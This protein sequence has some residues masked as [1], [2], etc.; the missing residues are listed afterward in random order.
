MKHTFFILFIPLL[1]IGCDVDEEVYDKYSAEEFYT[2]DIGADA[3][4]AGVYAQ[5]PGNWDGVG[6]AGADRGWYDI[7]S[8][9]SDEQVIPHRNTGD[10]ELA[11]ANLYLR[12]WLPTDPFFANAWNWLYNSIFKANLAIEQL[13]NA[14]TEQSKLAEAHALRAFFYY[15]L[16]DGFGNV[17]Y[18]IEN[19]VSVDAIPQVSR[20]ELF[21]LVVKELTE[22]IDDLSEEKGGL[23]YGR[24]NKWAGYSLLAKLY[25]N[26]EVYADTTMWEECRLI[27]DKVSEGGFSLHS[28]EEDATQPLGNKYYELFGDVC[29]DDETIFS[30]YT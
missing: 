6:Y 17:P 7:N 21:G 26:A 27:C 4:L 12:K 13:E 9:S 3:A 25:L 19:S 14:G 2:S 29:P 1:F 15:L 11:Y 10:W 16:L 28:G 30:I 8:M 23:Y 20:K 22:N 18:Y 5:I 24:F